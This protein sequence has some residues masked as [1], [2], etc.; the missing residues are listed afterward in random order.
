MSMILFHVSGQIYSIS[1]DVE[2][3]DGI[4]YKDDEFLFG[5]VWNI[6]LYKSLLMR[7]NP[8]FERYCNP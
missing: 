1:G 8:L 5:R 4:N 3:V 6:V 7:R 2:P